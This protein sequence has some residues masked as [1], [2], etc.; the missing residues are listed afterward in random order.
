DYISMTVYYTVAASESSG[1][2]GNATWLIQLRQQNGLDQ[3]GAPISS[4]S[5]SSSSSSATSTVELTHEAATVPDATEGTV[6]SA[7][8]S[9][10]SLENIAATKDWHW[11]SETDLTPEAWI[12]SFRIR[13]CERVGR[14]FA[15]KPAAVLT[16]VLPRLN[17]RL[18]KRSG[19]G[20][21]AP[22]AGM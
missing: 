14:W 20:C 8:S 1:G 6:S 17:D 22:G 3:W 4:S 2:C 7:S 9:S 5:S 13:V 11:V 19:F 15:A 12:I 16:S 21:A 10:S 18:K